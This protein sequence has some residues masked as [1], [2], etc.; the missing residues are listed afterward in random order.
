MVRKNYTAIAILIAG[1]MISAA[2]YLQ[3][4]RLTESNHQPTRDIGHEDAIG[5]HP[6]EVDL[7]WMDG[8]ELKGI[9]VEGWD[10]SKDEIYPQDDLRVLIEAWER[11]WLKD[12]DTWRSDDSGEQ[13]SPIRQHGGII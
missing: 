8:E 4:V 1:A 2:I 5:D 7:L 6:Q 9:N 10:L 12:N 3:P 11:L 13:N